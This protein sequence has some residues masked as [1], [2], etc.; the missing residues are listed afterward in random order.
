MV[1]M[2]MGEEDIREKQDAPRRQRVDVA[3]IE[4]HRA[5]LKQEI[6]I[7][8]GIA[9]TIV[10]K[11]WVEPGSHPR[12]L[13]RNDS[14]PHGGSLQSFSIDAGQRNAGRFAHYYNQ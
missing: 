5:P 13:T 6:H 7:D 10:H 14:A 12:T 4:Q 3:K 1:D 8:R 11:V 9:E 2:R